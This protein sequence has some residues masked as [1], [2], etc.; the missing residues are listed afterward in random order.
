MRIETKFIMSIAVQ[1]CFIA[2]SKISPKST[3]DDDTVSWEVLPS[4]WSFSSQVVKSGAGLA[5]ARWLPL[6]C[7]A[8]R[9]RAVLW[10]RSGTRNLVGRNIS[11]FANLLWRLRRHRRRWCDA[12]HLAERREVRQNEREDSLCGCS[13][14]DSVEGIIRPLYQSGVEAHGG[15][16]W[17]L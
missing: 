12:Y 3:G 7:H 16:Y 15:Q 6:G 13:W 17:G 8:I 5:V 4:C 2:S 10:G 14:G 9:P 11:R 1:Y